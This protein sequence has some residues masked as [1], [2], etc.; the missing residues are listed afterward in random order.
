MN[1]RMATSDLA[2][3]IEEGSRRGNSIPLLYVAI[4]TKADHF[5]DQI[6]NHARRQPIGTARHGHRHDPRA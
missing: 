5:R 3:T 2:F 4:V 6:A 1:R